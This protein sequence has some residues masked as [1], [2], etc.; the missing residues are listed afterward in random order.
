MKS[1][2]SAKF[3]LFAFG[4]ILSTLVGTSMAAPSHGSKRSA[5]PLVVSAA[6]VQVV[7]TAV[8]SEIVAEPTVEAEGVSIA[9]PTKG[10]LAILEAIFA[11]ILALLGL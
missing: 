10:S 6:P 9:V 1:Q 4:A 8:Q 2:F 5:E 3:R 11:F 7:A